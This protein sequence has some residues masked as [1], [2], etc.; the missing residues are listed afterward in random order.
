MDSVHDS[1]IETLKIPADDKNIR[2]LEYDPAFFDTKPPYEFFIEFLMFAGRTKE[3]KSRL[4]KSIVDRLH[5]KLGIDPKSVFI[6]INEQPADNWGIRGGISA[7]D[8]I[9][10]YKVNI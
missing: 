5:D 8:I 1:M 2:L 7:S 10:D 9:F 3:T 4:F 6:V